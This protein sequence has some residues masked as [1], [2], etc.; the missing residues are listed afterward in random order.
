[1]TRPAPEEGR[2]TPEAAA[3]LELWNGWTDIH[4]GGAYDVEGFVA[5]PAARPFDRVI[6]GVVGDVAGERLLHL[7]CHVGLDTMRLA[8]AGARDIVGVDFSPNAIAAARSVAGRMGIEATF[9][10]ADVCAL[11]D[12]VPL[13]AFDVVFTSYGTIMW[14]ADLEP[15]ADSIA[16]RLA[17]GGVF[18][19]V[20]AHPFLTVFDDEAGAPPLRVRYPYFSREANYYR[21]HGSYVDR[22]A[23][24][25]ADSY[26]WQHTFEEI[27]GVLARRGL[28]IGSLR[29]YP[30]ISWQAIDFMV[31]DTERL[32]RLPPEAGDIPLMF[33]LSARK[34][35]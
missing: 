12:E 9:V 31:P 10:E 1:M 14:L 5:D 16:S 26:S 22:D 2:M 11:P 3:N 8:L 4:M 20:D 18:H 27:V 34:P 7:Q 6:A 30:V 19:I 13:E 21:E 28:V 15:W 32:W 33:S 24:F 23:D 17:P 35:E 25:A 29:E